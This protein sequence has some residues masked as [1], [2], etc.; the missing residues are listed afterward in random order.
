MGSNL[1]AMV[2]YEEVVEVEDGATCKGTT[3][4]FGGGIQAIILP[5][6]RVSPGFKLRAGERIATCLVT[7]LAC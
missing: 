4:S 1:P 6:C 2:V 5:I 3:E 7:D